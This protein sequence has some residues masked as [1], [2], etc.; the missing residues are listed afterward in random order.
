[1]IVG[2]RYTHEPHRDA[3]LRPMVVQRSE[4][5]NS[6]VPRLALKY[7]VSPELNVYGSVSRGEKSGLT[8]VANLQSTPPFAPV[9]PEEITAYELGLKYASQN[10][11]FN[12]SGFYYD[13]KNKQEQVFT[14]TSG[15]V[16]NTGPIRI[17][18]FDADTTIRV[19]RN[20]SLRANAT[21]VPEA[22][23]RDFPNAASF[24][25]T[26]RTPI[27]TFPSVTIDVTGQR[28]L[29]SPEFSGNLT[30]DYTHETESGTVDASAN[31]AYSSSVFHDYLIKQKAYGTLGGRVGYTFGDSGMRIGLYG[32][33][34]TNKAYINSTLLSGLGVTAS[35]ARPREVGISLSFAN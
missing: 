2:G 32:R 23:Y 10:V 31:F 9:D 22:E 24:D 12:L 35:Y 17:Y 21:W 30:L 19:S 8:G 1:V 6:F 26:R 29:R 7:D 15:Y 5:F 20:F 13:Y 3:L 14:G 25:I 33:N 18:G 28:L 27:G 11:S 34:L 4:T 16:Q